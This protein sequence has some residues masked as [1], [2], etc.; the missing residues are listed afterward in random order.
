MS[1]LCALAPHR[2]ERARARG[3]TNPQ[4]KEWVLANAA[5]SLHK[6]EHCLRFHGTPGVAACNSAL[7]SKAS[8][9]RPQL[10]GKVP[11]GLC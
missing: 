7:I 1:R 2:I 8:S 10:L 11:T 6:G 4:G 5:S 3:S 9:L